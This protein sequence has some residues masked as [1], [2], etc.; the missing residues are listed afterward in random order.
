M[1]PIP[2]PSDADSPRQSS[3]DA[4]PDDNLVDLEGV[5]LAADCIVRACLNSPQRTGRERALAEI[6]RLG[7]ASGSPQAFLEAVVDLALADPRL[8]SSS[9][10]DGLQASLNVLGSTLPVVAAA[11]YLVAGTDAHPTPIA[12]TGQAGSIE[13]LAGVAA[14]AIIE[15]RPAEDGNS[16]AAPVSSHSGENAAV[17]LRLAQPSPPSTTKI[18]GRAAAH[19]TAHL[20]RI[21]LEERAKQKEQTL[22]EVAEKRLARVGYDLHDGPLQ[23]L[24]LLQADLRLTTGDIEAILPA[25]TRATV[26]EAFASLGEQVA[27]IERDIRA[28]SL[29]SE[30]TG[31]TRGSLTETLRREALQATRGTTVKLH[32]DLADTLPALSNSQRIAIYRIAQEAFANIR[33]HSN[34]TTITA[35]LGTHD[36]TVRLRISDNGYG[37]N[38][39]EELDAAR[40]RGRLGL[41]GAAERIRLLGGELTIAS[42]PGEGTTIELALRPWRGAQTAGPP[43]A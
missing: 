8:F 25:D 34:A 29:S 2:G 30:S 15:Q 41:V 7:A 12:V 43:P 23:A 32:L 4:T 3:D 19:L 40:S 20:E 36:D 9:P 33:E 6:T 24:A 37:F 38:P 1:R 31:A 28:I 16:I 26:R 17:A 39:D 18:L 13:T 27:A 10:V 42:S 14:R 22:L 5:R 21:S 11:V 35:T